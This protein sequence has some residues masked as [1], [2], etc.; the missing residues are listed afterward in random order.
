MN[1]TGIP[2]VMTPVV[3]STSQPVDG[4]TGAPVTVTT[5]SAGDVHHML[6]VIGVLSLIIYFLVIVAGSGPAA[7]RTVVTLMIALVVLQGITHANP[8]VSWLAAHPLTE[9]TQ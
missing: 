7:G 8:V 6:I 4:T 1:A 2:L 5:T 9:Q 3:P